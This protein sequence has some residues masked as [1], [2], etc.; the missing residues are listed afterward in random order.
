MRERMEGGDREDGGN[1]HA[2]PRPRPLERPGRPALA[3]VLLAFVG[4]SSW[5]CRERVQ[6]RPVSLHAM[7][8][9]LVG[10]GVVVSERERVVREVIGALR[11]A[12]TPCNIDLYGPAA[13][14]VERTFLDD[15]PVVVVSPES[16]HRA[17]PSR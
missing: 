11:A 17:E 4:V 13:R 16:N 1:P 12:E 9:A 8:H 5:V 15:R 3:A 14:F 7:R 6:Q 10:K 2:A